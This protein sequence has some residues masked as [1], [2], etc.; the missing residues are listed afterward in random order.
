MK[1][2]QVLSLDEEMLMFTSYRYCIGRKTYVTSLAPYIGKKYYPLLSVERAEFTAQ[3]IRRCIGDCLQFNHPSFEYDS[4]VAEK[5]RNPLSD[6]I[7][8]LNN[9]VSDHSDLQGIKEIVCYKDSYKDNEPKKY[10]VVRCERKTLEVFEHDITDLLEWDTLASLFDR[11]NHKLVTIKYNGE[12]RVIRCF[13]AWTKVTVPTGERQG[14]L[15][16][17]EPTPW[18]YK[19]VFISLGAY[20]ESGRQAGHLCEEYIIDVKDVDKE[21]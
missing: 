11:K 12:T 14:N 4:T 8:W 19:K 1:K 9:N 17:Y 10:D 20:L 7:I 3:D 16:W 13:E 6:Y 5:E 18:K 21:L 2:D 15:M